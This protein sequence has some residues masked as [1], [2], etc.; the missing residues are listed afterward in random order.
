MSPQEG[1]AKELERVL[2]VGEVL[3]RENDA[4]EEMFF[5]RAGKI[6]IS[7]ALG[8]KEKTLAVL[9]QGDF[10]GEMSAIDGSPRSATATALEE[11]QILVIDRSDLKGKIKENPLIEYILATM[12]KRLRDADKQIRYLLIKDELA[13]TVSLLIAE[14]KE[15]GTQRGTAIELKFDPT[16]EDLAIKTG[17]TPARLS[18]IIQRLVGLGLIRIQGTVLTMPSPPNLED[19]LRYVILREKFKEKD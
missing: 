11:S 10:F 13:R 4:G 19:Y 17:I 16:L 18:E 12:V 3:F 1:K 2:K 6:R 9:R 15:E 14:G 7:K 8:D 5:I